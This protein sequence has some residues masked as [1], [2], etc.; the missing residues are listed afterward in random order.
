MIKGPAAVK[1]GEINETQAIVM[2]LPRAV[3]ADVNISS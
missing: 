1:Y 2:R 3:A